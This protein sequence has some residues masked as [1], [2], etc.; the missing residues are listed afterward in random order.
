MSVLGLK[1]EACK[2]SVGLCMK[3]VNKQEIEANRTGQLNM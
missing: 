1:L 3:A 2:Q